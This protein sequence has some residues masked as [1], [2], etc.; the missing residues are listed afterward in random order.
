MRSFFGGAAL[1]ARTDAPTITSVSPA[2][3]ARGTNVVVQG[4]NLQEASVTWTGTNRRGPRDPPGAMK[5]AP[6]QATVSPDGTQITFAVPDGGDTSQGIM[7]PGGMNRFT[8]TTPGGSITKTFKVTGVNTIG[9]KPV[10]T[11]LMPKRA[12]PGAQITIFGHHFTGATLVKIGG[13]NAT[14]GSRPTR[15]SC[16][17]AD[18]G[19]LRQLDC[20]DGVRHRSEHHCFTVTGAST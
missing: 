3:G 6:I 13:M 14:Y 15:G 7:A 20:Q 17:G 5:A 18:A 4:T 16:E 8:V 10:I 9:L 11:Q 1:A 12:R 19:A 2:S